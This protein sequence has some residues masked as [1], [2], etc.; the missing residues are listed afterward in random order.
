MQ[1]SAIL[2]SFLISYC[3]LLGLCRCGKRYLNGNRFVNGTSSEID[4]CA[5]PEKQ[6][7][8]NQGT[9]ANLTLRFTVFRLRSLVAIS[10]STKYR[11]TTR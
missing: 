11:C 5:R 7:V 1:I 2:P 9:D 6:N 4:N 10:W 3:L 8:S